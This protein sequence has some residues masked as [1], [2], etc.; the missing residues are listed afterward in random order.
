M[1]YIKDYEADGKPYFSQ[2]NNNLTTN[3]NAQVRK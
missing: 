3:V 2:I 1:N